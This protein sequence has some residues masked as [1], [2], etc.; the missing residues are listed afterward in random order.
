MKPILLRL[1]LSDDAARRLR[2]LAL[3][4]GKT[5]SQIIRDAIEGNR[6]V[7]LES[8]RREESHVGRRRRTKKDNP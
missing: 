4:E 6:A 5:I 2:S 8:E 3:R 1:E 7:E